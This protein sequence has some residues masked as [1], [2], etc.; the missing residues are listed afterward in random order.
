M[1]RFVCWLLGI[2]FASS[3][4]T[5]EA[6]L[7]DWYGVWKFSMASASDPSGTVSCTGTIKAE[8]ATQ[9]S[10]SASCAASDGFVFSFPGQIVMKDGQMSLALSVTAAGISWTMNGIANDGTTGACNGFNA[11]AVQ[12]DV[13]S[14]Q[15][16]G[17]CR[18][19][20]GQVLSDSGSWTMSRITGSTQVPPP[21]TTQAVFTAPTGRMPTAAVSVNPSGTFGKA[22][23]IVTLDLSKVL[24][25]GS[26]A[27]FGQFA[28]GYNIY[29]AALVPSGALG[30]TSATWFALPA[31]RNW[32]TLG[33]PIAAYMEGLA[34]N[35]TN[36]VAITILQ[37][38][39][40]TGLVGSEI[41]IGYGTSDTEMLA[42]NRY[43]GIYKV[44]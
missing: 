28:A 27:G 39:D 36:S 34:Q 41:Y 18:D 6:A 43:R 11:G 8:T 25:G 29:V 33:S 12:G 26:F 13:A 24:S 38:L 32:S 21:P 4:L 16:T 3:P 17:T 19:S 20:N 7:Q 14:G 15:W 44:Q 37:G 30:L 1:T 9:A 10:A 31:T 23:L 22:T 5:G 40:V 35:A 2:L 42:A